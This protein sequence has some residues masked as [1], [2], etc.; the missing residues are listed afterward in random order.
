MKEKG[1]LLELINT[2]A[3]RKALL[4]S[5]GAMSFQQL[6]G[7][8]VV[9]FY[10][11]TIF[12]LAGDTFLSTTNATI[13]VA[14]IL[15]A[16]AGVAV[17]LVKMYGIRNMLIASSAGMVVF[18]VPIIYQ[19]NTIKFNYKSHLKSAICVLIS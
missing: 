2:V 16:T 19:S 17:P 13:V 14:V 4:L 7:I 6:S 15:I 8:N 18:Q 1:T 3:N 10:S 5:C 11:E 9:L 12:R